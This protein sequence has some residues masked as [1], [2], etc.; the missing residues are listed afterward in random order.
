VPGAGEEQRGKV[1]GDL[2]V[3]AEK[4]DL[5][6]DDSVYETGSAVSLFNE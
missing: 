5:H 2:T 6:C 1:E 4:E 3:A